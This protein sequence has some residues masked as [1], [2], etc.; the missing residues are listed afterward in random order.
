MRYDLVSLF[1][2]G[3]SMEVH[4][5]NQLI[6]RQELHLSERQLQELVVKRE[7]SLEANHLI[8]LSL[9]SQA[10]IA[11]KLEQSTLI[12]KENY[13]QYLVDLQESFYFLRSNLPF[14]YSD[15]DILEKLMSIFEEYEGLISHVQGVLEEWVITENL[16]GG[17]AADGIDDSI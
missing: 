8:D 1:N 7:E 6:Q 9:E 12:T 2:G 15:E 13:F 10:Y 3:R 14:S 17:A 4:K 11:V 5:L 16:E